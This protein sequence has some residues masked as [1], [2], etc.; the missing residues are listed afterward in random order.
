MEG[1]LPLGLRRRPEPAHL[2]FSLPGGPDIIKVEE[3]AGRPTL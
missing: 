2:P 3:R 1:E